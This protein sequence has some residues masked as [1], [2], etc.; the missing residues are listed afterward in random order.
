MWNW[1]MEKVRDKYP[2]A[3]AAG[4]LAAGCILAL[5]ASGDIAMGDALATAA[6]MAAFYALYRIAARFL[7]PLAW[8]GE[9]LFCGVGL[10]V[11]AQL[12]SLGE[13]GWDSSADGPLHELGALWIAALF[14]F[15]CGVGTRFAVAASSLA[16][17]VFGTANYVLTQFRGRPFML[18]DFASLRTAMNVSSSYELELEPVFILGA[19]YTLAFALLAWRLFPPQAE[20][21]RV[22]RALRHILPVAASA[23]WALLC[24]NTGLMY[25]NGIYMNWNDNEFRSSSVMYFIATTSTLDIDPPEGYSSEAL[26]AI[27]LQLIEQ[28]GDGAY[29]ALREGEDR[30]DIVVVMSE[31]FSDTRELGEFE[32][33]EPVLSFFDELASESVHGHV[34]S[35]VIGGNTANSEY[36]LLTG[37][38]CMFLPS[39][40]VAYQSYINNP[41][42]TLVSTLKAQDYYAAAFHPYYSTGWNRPQVYGLFGFDETHFLE[43]Y[44]SYPRLRGYPRDDW[45]Y[46][47]LI[48]LYERLDGEREGDSGIFLFNITMQNHGGYT[49]STYESTVNVTGH[50]GEFPVTEQ[51]LS[52]IR[53]TDEESRALIDY[54]RGVEREVIVL[55]FGDHQP[56]L[57]KEFYD[58]VY[59]YDTSELELADEQRKYITPFY[60]WSNR[61]LEAKDEGYTSLNYLSSLLLETA[62]LKNSPYGYFLRS[63]RESWPAV[64]AYG[65]MDADGVWHDRN[66]EEVLSDGLLSAYRILQ[67]NRLFDPGDYREE[68][69]MTA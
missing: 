24:F 55:F 54:F 23:A 7:R 26:D 48:E 44:S 36:E 15:F 50:E 30:P 63:L 60:I 29:Y 53:L 1:D 56:K 2:V 33:S 37:D 9:A 17:L 4:M 67:Y 6:A 51:Y 27:E 66:S 68:L 38:S 40:A 32:T 13:F 62:G 8:L 59:G 21:V 31:S 57:E 11:A 43:E 22:L 46:E 49:S 58:L 69:Y 52:L 10:Y 45:N 18:M 28:A 12:L 5:M 64:N 41:V 47:R 65:A 19:V 39:G 16:V 35:S 61:G 14:A 25:G 34:Y 3:E 20:P 42:G